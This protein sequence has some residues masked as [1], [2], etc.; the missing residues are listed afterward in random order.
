MKTES[1]LDLLDQVNKED[2]LSRY[3]KLQMRKI[4]T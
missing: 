4:L 2:H 3:K 1:N